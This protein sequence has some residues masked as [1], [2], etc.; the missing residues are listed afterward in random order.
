VLRRHAQR[1]RD[2][3]Q[4]SAGSSGS[5]SRACASRTSHRRRPR[6]PRRAF[7]RVPPQSRRQRTTKHL[8]ARS[9]CA[10]WDHGHCR[11]QRTSRRP[12]CQS[13]QRGGAAHGRQRRQPPPRYAHGPPTPVVG[14]VPYDGATWSSS[15]WPPDHSG[16]KST[17]RRKRW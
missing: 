2:D 14:Y 3:E 7:A 10:H 12:R 11:A 16:A 4:R 9:S 15:C 5:E 8:Q 17:R 1:G 6:A 13:G